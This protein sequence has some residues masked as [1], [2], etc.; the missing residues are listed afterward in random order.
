MRKKKKIE[1]IPPVRISKETDRW[2]R[3]R[4]DDDN[5]DETN[6]GNQTIFAFLM[7]I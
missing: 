2:K 1:L 6:E 3:I 7:I 5:D 4:R